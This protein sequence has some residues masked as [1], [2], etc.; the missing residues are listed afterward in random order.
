M[1]QQHG[2][3]RKMEDGRQNSGLQRGFFVLLAQELHSD[4]KAFYK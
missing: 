3:F 2:G 1:G 4:G